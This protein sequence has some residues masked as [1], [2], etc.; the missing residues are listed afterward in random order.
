[1]T[2]AR[3]EAKPVMIDFT[4]EWCTP[5]REFD[6]IT[7]HHSD[8]VK[9]SES[10]IIMI[11]VDLTKKG[12]VINEELVRHH[13]VKGVPTILFFNRQGEELKHLRLVDFL[14]PDRF[15]IQLAEIR[16]LSEK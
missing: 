16:K 11:K 13:A 10:E 6:E 7:F 2:K 4:A 12:N 9:L 1:M 8:I 5:C 3:I 15:L 14:P